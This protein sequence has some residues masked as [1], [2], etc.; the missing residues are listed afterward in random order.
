ML[1]LSKT[2][3]SVLLDSADFLPLP[4]SWNPFTCMSSEMNIEVIIWAKILSTIAA[5]SGG[6][7]VFNF[8][9]FQ[10]IFIF[11]F[12]RKYSYITKSKCKSVVPFKTINNCLNCIKEK[13]QH[14]EPLSAPTACEHLWLSTDAH[15]IRKPNS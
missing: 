12:G 15:L 13:A 7:K 5:F 2:K 1:F 4:Q 8:C 10:T 11:I 9:S 14:D 3:Y 6:S